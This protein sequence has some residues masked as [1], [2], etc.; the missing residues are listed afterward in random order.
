MNKKIS[1]NK[2]DQ[3][4]RENKNLNVYSILA[5]LYSFLFITMEFYW[6]LIY[7]IEMTICIYSHNIF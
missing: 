6:L 4:I 2:Y 3:N 5:F 7:I 1:Y